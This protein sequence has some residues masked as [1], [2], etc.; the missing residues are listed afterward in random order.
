MGRLHVT[1]VSGYGLKP[2][3]S[4]GKADPYVT[5]TWRN[6]TYKTDRVRKTLEPRWNCNWVLEWE[7]F[8]PNPPLEFTVFDWNRW[9][10]ND[11]MG[12]LSIQLHDLEPHKPLENSY[13]LD[14]QGFLVLKILFVGKPPPQ[15]AQ[16]AATNLA[17]PPFVPTPSRQDPHPLSSTPTNSNN[18]RNSPTPP[19]YGAAAAPP[20]PY[21]M[22]AAPPPAYGQ[23]AA[24]PAYGDGVA[25]AAPPPSGP[26]SFKGPMGEGFYE[27][28]VNDKDE[29]DGH[30]KYTLA[31]G[32]VYEGQYKE[33]VKHGWGKCT[34]ADGTFTEGGWKDGKGHGYQTQTFANGSKYEG[35]C[36]A[37][38]G[39][40]G[41]GKY[42][43]FDGGFYEGEFKNDNR[44]GHG[45]IV[46]VNG[47][48]YEGQ[49]KG[50]V[51]EGFGRHRYED[52]TYE[53]EFRDWERKG[54]GKYL[55]NDGEIYEGEFECGLKQGVGKYTFPNESVYEGRFREGSYHGHGKLVDAEDGK[56][57]EGGFED[58]DYHGQGKFTYANG[59]REIAWF[60]NDKREGRCLLIQQGGS[61]VAVLQCKEDEI[62]S[63]R[64]VEGPEVEIVMREFRAHDEFLQ[65]KT[66]SVLEEVRA[67]ESNKQRVNEKVS[68]A[69]EKVSEAVAA[70]SEV[71]ERH[72]KEPPRAGART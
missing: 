35:E 4:N 42:T 71:L 19:A 18:N 61:I 57:Y 40:D 69:V 14:T 11:P 67:L 34:F 68:E 33:G 54:Y 2:M 70:T 63:R 47:Q 23:N 45:R 15:T 29:P 50:G 28:E 17:Q 8:S 46:Y 72:R 37:G 12:R 48:L 39:W 22:N 30:G 43:F 10:S 13:P 49:M 66:Q 55:F 20:P 52:G 3:D 1:V 9:S 21:G 41:F 65:Q 36:K 56:V 7:D 38:K 32:D 62:L 24:P 5:L 25:V 58:G 53:G 16:G 60:M 59:D 31:D 27:G 26:R 44:E 6:H 64:E 51:P